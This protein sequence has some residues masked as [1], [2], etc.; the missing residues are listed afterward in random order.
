LFKTELFV[1]HL[2]HFGVFNHSIGDDRTYPLVLFNYEPNLSIKFYRN[3]G[4]YKL[5]LYET[6]GINTTT[7]IGFNTKLYE[8][9][10]HLLTYVAENTKRESYLKY[11]TFYYLM[12]MS[13][14]HYNYMW[15]GK[16]AFFGTRRL[17]LS[18]QLPRR[19]KWPILL[20]PWYLTSLSKSAKR[21][22]IRAKIRRQNRSA[23]K[24]E[25]D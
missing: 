20:L 16:R 24:N 25:K 5:M 3:E 13:F 12:F 22:R 7:G 19:V 15:K 18:T 6:E 9:M 14:A 21:Y 23:I 11:F 10:H 1:K 17:I 2:D 8:T 4:Y